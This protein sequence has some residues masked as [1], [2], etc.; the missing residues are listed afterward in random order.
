MKI[1]ILSAL[2]GA[3]LSTGAIA[4]EAPAQQDCSVRA[5]RA[6]AA[7]TIPYR[8]FTLP[9]G[10]RVIVH[11]DRT[12]P[13]VSVNVTY[14]VGSKYEPADRAGF[15]HL[16][17]HLMF[18]GSDQ[19]AGD[20]Y[21]RMREIGAT[22]VNANTTF[23]TTTFYET[24]PTGALD[25][26]LF[27]EAGRMANMDA[28]I[29][30]ALLAIHRGIVKNEKRQNE[31]A[32]YAIGAENS[33]GRL[34][35][36][37]HPYGHPVVGSMRALDAATSEQARA[38]HQRYYTPTNAVLVLAG[39]I[40][41]ETAQRKVTQWFGRIARGSPINRPAPPLP[42][43]IAAS[44]TLSDRVPQTSMTRHWVTPGLTAPDGPALDL[45]ARVLGTLTGAWLDGALVREK[46]A[47]TSIMASA[48]ASADIGTFIVNAMLAAGTSP[49]HLSQ[50]ID[51]VLARLST[52]GPTPDDLCRVVMRDIGFQTQTLETTAARAS[53][54]AEGEMIGGDPIY[55]LRQTA[56]QAALTPADIRRAAARWLTRPSYTL[57]IVPGTR[58]TAE[59]TASPP[60][61]RT[62]VIAPAPKPM[63]ALPP[64]GVEASLRFPTITRERLSNGLMLVHAQRPATPLTRFA[65][66]FD[67]GTAVD[68]SGEAGAQKL[69]YAMLAEGT[70]E[71]D[72]VRQVEANERLGAQSWLEVTPDQGV[73]RLTVTSSNAPTA[74]DMLAQAVRHPAFDLAA[75]ARV[76]EAKL[77]QIGYEEINP[78]S[79]ARRTLAAQLYGADS[80]YG[81]SVDSGD[82][83]AV[84][85]ITRDRLVELHRAWVRPEKA[86]L[87]VVSDL[88][89][90]TVRRMA[91]AAFGDWHGV[92]PA[93]RRP[94][95]ANIAVAPRT[96]SID[97]PGSA[98]SLILAAIRT[99]ITGRS[100][101]D[102]LFAASIAAE[103]LGGFRGRI[104]RDLRERNGWSYGATGGFDVRADAVSWIMTASVENAHNCDAI[105]HIDALVRGFLG[106]D[107]LRADE[108]TQTIQA[109][110]AALP[111]RFERGDSV[112][113]SL[114]LDQR[115]GR[116]PGFQISVEQ[117]YR[118]LT[119]A[120]ANDA[121][122]AMLDPDRLNIVIIGD[123]RRVAC[124]PPHKM[125]SDGSEVFDPAV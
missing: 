25:R 14:G 33:F 84:A 95:A 80:S 35:P 5:A 91:Q 50:D 68:G 40:D 70:A 61:A 51:A 113:D 39:D 63:T 55:M 120:Q 11:T 107:P 104:N 69:L 112:L 98:Q 110:L 52:Q 116:S 71:R 32:P 38:W 83:A 122:R 27:L 28:A 86:A 81:R 60:A 76:R 19:A 125:V 48:G 65:L 9:N 21:A 29:T 24:V 123:S 15:A 58:S 43:A 66:T 30:P 41:L 53:T 105:A 8:R 42:P 77:A 93:G 82:A 59:R 36:P 85:A 102:Q 37:G 96:I 6:A 2:L 119:R 90:A 26:T 73:A 100:T 31:D 92:G 118:S 4:R 10:L 17:E 106:S 79:L 22:G 108:F 18:A 16:F 94:P 89:F 13:V 75:L 56:R 74:L 46:H 12:T 72:R 103:A 97:Q 99:P 44:D 64:L 115:L 47:A 87:I 7:L 88:P 109:N 20:F 54:L 121:I 3:V 45:A 111:G 23:D 78:P 117:R 124:P 62:P 67:G 57:T 34:F 114:V 101:T 49:T 1:P